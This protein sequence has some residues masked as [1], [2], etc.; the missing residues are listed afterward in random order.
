MNV[1]SR[2]YLDS[3]FRVFV[4]YIKSMQLRCKTTTICIVVL[5]SLA[6]LLGGIV[7]RA[8]LGFA[9]LA[10]VQ[11]PCVLLYSWGLVL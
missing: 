7:V 1:A 11:A 6:S 8:L 9:V 3:V 5:L 2:M 10:T 4:V